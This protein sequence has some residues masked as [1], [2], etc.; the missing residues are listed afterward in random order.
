VKPTDAELVAGLRLRSRAAFDEVYAR[1]HA[2]IFRF[3]LR[4]AGRRDVAEDLFQETWVS[5]ARHADR[6][7][8]GTDLAAWLFTVARNR[9]TSFRRWSLLDW[10]RTATLAGEPRDEAAP[11]DHQ[12][13][14][15]ETAALLERAL[16]E[17]SPAQREVLLLVAVE[18]LEQQQVAEV[19]GIRHDTLRQRLS[20]ARAELA[21]RLEAASRPGRRVA[22]GGA[23]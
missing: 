12:A 9:H 3:L 21:A 13:D 22:A 5:V 15:R 1:Y 8:E 6:L 2:R 16:A 19:L 10:S 18:G 11:I 7:A 23:R 4:L 17:L 14:A 20:R